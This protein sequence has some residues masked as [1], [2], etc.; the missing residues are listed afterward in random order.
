MPRRSFS[1][2]LERVK[3]PDHR[4]LI[5]DDSSA[6]CLAARSVLESAGMTVV[7]TA[8]TLATAVQAA[9]SSHPDLILVDIDLGGES[10]FDVVE[11]L[12]D[13]DPR[14]TMVLVSTHDEEDFADMV[15]ASSAIGFLPKFELSA[16]R[17]L[18]I[19]SR[20]GDGA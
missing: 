11:A 12:H 16:D 9:R 17:I 5:V 18:Q 6:F 8:S 4:C 13:D 15:E 2:T 10:G 19:M 1:D 14:L 7:G 20:N 3:P